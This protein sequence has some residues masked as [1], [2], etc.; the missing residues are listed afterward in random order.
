M[1][2][3]RHVLFPLSALLFAACDGQLDVGDKSS[4]A[5]TLQDAGS[6]PPSSPPAADAASPADA[7]ELPIGPLPPATSSV[8]GTVNGKAWK[9]G[10][11]IAFRG[12]W[13][14]NSPHL[15]VFFSDSS[16]ALSCDAFVPIAS[17]TMI[18]IELPAEKAKA[19]TTPLAASDVVILDESDATCVSYPVGATDGSVTL[20]S[21]TG[22]IEGTLEAT[23]A[24]GTV[25]GAFSIP[26]CPGAPSPE[27]WCK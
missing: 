24:N 23:F 7:G 25:S 1:Q 2:T 20:S 13:G 21:V 15:R 3:T 14:S 22:M 12:D 16:S 9:P 18:R 10:S 6:T 4:A 11:M 8:E 19:T 5:Q 17:S 27:Q 26:V